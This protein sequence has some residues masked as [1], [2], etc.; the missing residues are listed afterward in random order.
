MAAEGKRNRRP[1]KA[2]REGTAVIF[3]PKT[4]EGGE[5]VQAWRACGLRRSKGR[6]RREGGWHWGSEQ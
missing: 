3:D 2:R 1:R 6:A 4:R 5:R